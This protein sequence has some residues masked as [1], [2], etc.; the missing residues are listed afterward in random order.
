MRRLPRLAVR[1]VAT[2]GLLGRI[3]DIRSDEERICLCLSC[4]FL[5]IRHR[6]MVSGNVGNALGLLCVFRL[7]SQEGGSIFS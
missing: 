1:L 3:R 6:W 7:G 4:V 5:N 2:R